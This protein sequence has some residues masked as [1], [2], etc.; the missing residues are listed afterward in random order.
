[1]LAKQPRAF[2]L[3]ALGSLGTGFATYAVSAIM[4]LYLYDPAARGGLGI[5]RITA[6]QIMAVFSALGYVAGIFGS[7]AADRLVGLRKPYLYGTLLKIAAIALL[8]VPGGGA[9]LFFTSLALQILASAVTGQSLNALVG[10]IYRRRGGMRSTA[11]TLL[12]ITSNIGAA[13]PIVTGAVALSFGYHWAFLVAAGV[14]LATTLPYVLLHHGAFGDLGEVAPDPLSAPA[15]RQLQKRLVGGLLLAVV[16]LGALAA[17]GWLTATH[18]SNL[19][20]ALGLMLPV[21]YLIK[22][23]HSP[24]TSQKEAQRVKMYAAFLFG[25]SLTMLVYGQATGILSLY[26]VGRVNLNLLGWHLSAASFQTVP[27]VFAVLFGSAASAVWSRLGRRQPSESLK[28]G[29]GLLLWGAGPL[30]MMLPLGLFPASVKVSPLWLIGFYALITLGETLT[31]P[32]GMAMA[33][34]VAP[35]AFI[36]QMMTVYTLSQAA[37]SGLSAIAA[38]FYRPGHEV[39]YF[40][41]IGLIAIGWGLLM[42]GGRR[43]ITRQVGQEG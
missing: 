22:I 28:F 33:S 9:G 23:I 19:V 41:V 17:L 24:K 6:T 42:I 29:V 4:I 43:A 21:G 39:L 32:V 16:V 8:A 26:T 27:A 5:D 34:R 40:L 3:M 31:S 1:M 18:F 37:G 35:A 13:G 36:T 11:F 14:L 12:Y 38:N 30:L 15:L 7:Y 20:G 25:N 2:K 10:L